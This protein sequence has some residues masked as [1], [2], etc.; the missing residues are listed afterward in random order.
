MPTEP[1]TTPTPPVPSALDAAARE[2][3][4]SPFDP[5]SPSCIADFKAGAVWM[6]ERVLAECARVE[7]EHPWCSNCDEYSNDAMVPIAR[8]REVLGDE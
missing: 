6:R 2:H 5:A 7:T 1:G 4:A 8:L 3:C